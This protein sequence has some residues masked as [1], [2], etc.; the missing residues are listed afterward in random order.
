MAWLTALGEPSARKLVLA[1]HLR[2]IFGVPSRPITLEPSWLSWQGGTVRR[3]AETIYDEHDFE[4]LSVL[5]DALEDAGCA[6]A[7][8]LA[9]LRG[10]GPHARGC[11]VLDAL[12]GRE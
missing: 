1:S 9:H 5:G 4:R 3:L 8:L 10:A 6:D 12:L 2:D 7:D 11:H